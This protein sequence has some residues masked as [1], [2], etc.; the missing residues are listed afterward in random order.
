MSACIMAA[1]IENTYAVIFLIGCAGVGD[2]CNGSRCTNDALVKSIPLR[3][4]VRF[5][6]TL[7]DS[8]AKNCCSWLFMSCL[9]LKLMVWA[10]EVH[11]SQTRI[12][13]LPMFLILNKSFCICGGCFGHEWEVAH[14]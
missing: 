1:G 8:R 6:L 12:Q 13:E 2:A 4:F 3:A 11:K 7:A 9:L 14:E 5:K 10:I